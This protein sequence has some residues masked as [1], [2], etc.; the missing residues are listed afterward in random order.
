MK[1]S[2]VNI[3][4]FALGY[5]A[6]SAALQVVR[7]L[8][9]EYITVVESLYNSSLSL[10][11]ACAPVISIFGL[12]KK[13]RWSRIVASVIIAAQAMLNIFS[14]AYMYFV[15]PEIGKDMLIVALPI[16]LALLILAYKTFSSV[17]LKSYL[18][19]A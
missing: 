13:L 4:Y 2:I 17:Q 12:V 6:F 14:S 1:P 10:F 11:V 8:G 9:I 16:S 5:L 18:S 3:L 7:I 19:N 15:N